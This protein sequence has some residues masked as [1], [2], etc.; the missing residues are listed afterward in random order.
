MIQCTQTAKEARQRANVKNKKKQREITMYVREC[1]IIF[2]V[3]TKYTNYML[4]TF[5]T[6]WELFAFRRLANTH[7]EK[8]Y[9]KKR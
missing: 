2:A 1:K 7:K 3:W 8:R 6:L 5:L 4:H 9:A